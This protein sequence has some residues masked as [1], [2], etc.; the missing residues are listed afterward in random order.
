[1]GSDD[2]KVEAERIK[3]RDAVILKGMEA[4]INDIA[5]KQAMSMCHGHP[6]MVYPRMNR[7]VFAEVKA[8][9]VAACLEAIER[10]GCI[11]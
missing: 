2:W 10:K 1:M 4:G 5:E 7:D 11:Y 8:C 9:I 3:S 6:G